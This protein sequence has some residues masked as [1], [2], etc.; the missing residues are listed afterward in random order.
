M[1]INNHLNNVY[2]PV[3]AAFI[4]IRIGWNCETPCKTGYFGFLCLTQC[5]VWGLPVWW[6]DWVPVTTNTYEKVCVSKYWPTFL[7]L[8]LNCY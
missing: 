2:E 3:I 4:N 6:R 5:E 8:M 1:I 7:L